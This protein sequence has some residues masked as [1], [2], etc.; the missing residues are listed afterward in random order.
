MS[1]ILE[2]WSLQRVSKVDIVV[3]VRWREK[4]RNDDKEEVLNE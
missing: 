4:V 1:N 3:I 2:R